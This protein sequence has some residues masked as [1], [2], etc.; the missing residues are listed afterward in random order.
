M[1]IRREAP[2]GPPG[3]LIVMQILITL[4]LGAV[5][6][7]IS[8]MQQQAKP[9]DQEIPVL[10]MLVNSDSSSSAFSFFPPG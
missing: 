7:L 10:D 1:A 4:N 8:L 6:W 2:D 3:C 9:K 5:C